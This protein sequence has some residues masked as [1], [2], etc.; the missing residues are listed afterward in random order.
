M[1]CEGMHDFSIEQD[2]AYTYQGFSSSV[3]Y[4]REKV[5]EHLHGLHHMVVKGTGKGLYLCAGAQVEQFFLLIFHSF[6]V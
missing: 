4:S 3:T 2:G 6:R 5:G 1:I